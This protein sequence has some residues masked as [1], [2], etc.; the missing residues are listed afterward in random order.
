MFPESSQV[1]VSEYDKLLD[2]LVA[3]PDILA[4]AFLVVMFPEEM[5][6]VLVHV[7]SVALLKDPLA[8][9]VVQEPVI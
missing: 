4:Y 6:G 2:P 7:L 3:V 1:S 5:V 8:E 9:I